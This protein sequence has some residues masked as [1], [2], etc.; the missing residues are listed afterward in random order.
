LRQTTS[1]GDEAG[2]AFI[3]LHEAI[4]VMTP[5]AELSMLRAAKDRLRRL[6]TPRRNK[7]VRVA[8][9]SE[10]GQLAIAYLERLPTLPAQSERMR[11]SWFRDGLLV[12]LLASRPIRLSNLA[13]LEIGRHLTRR[14]DNLFHIALAAE[15]TKDRLPMD[16]SCPEALTPWMDLY[17]SRHRP[18]LLRGR[19]TQRLWISMR[20][21]P[22][23]NQSVYIA[24]CKLTEQ[25]RDRPINPHLFR[26]CLVSEMAERA[27][28]QLAAASRILGHA[29]L[30]IANKHYNHA[31][32]LTAI[33]AHQK[34][35]EET[36]AE[37]EISP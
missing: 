28:E 21:A 18:L 16:F 15:E 3:D 1:P 37:L 30:S 7:Q 35:L 8:H 25:L 2:I 34:A 11:A 27:P 24:V 33:K 4:L 5:E 23:S 12:L 19:S 9:S 31:Q 13:A 26:D 20:G 22:V 17:I 36:F 32:M 29:S 14:H 10:L 6:Q